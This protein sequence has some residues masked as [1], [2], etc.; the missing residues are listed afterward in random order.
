MAAQPFYFNI[1]TAKDFCIQGVNNSY[2]N[3]SAGTCAQQGYAVSNGNYTAA[4][5]TVVGTVW[6]KAATQPV[7]TPSTTT[8]SSTWSI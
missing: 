5:G 7:V 3:G 2:I 8:S 4:N 6:L 1:V